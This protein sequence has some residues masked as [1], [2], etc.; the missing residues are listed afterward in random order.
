MD[1]VERAFKTFAQA[2]LACFVGDVTVISINW[3]QVL[4]VAGTAA[5]I[6][7]LTSLA[8]ATFTRGGNA[9]LVRGDTI[10]PSTYG[11]KACTSCS[12][13]DTVQTIL[14]KDS[15]G[16]ESR[17]VHGPGQRPHS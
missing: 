14:P 8:T 4:A 12:A 2:L 1:A 3:S 5:L 16:A 10:A 15:D 11:V 17:I 7:I 13:S 6:S 9:S